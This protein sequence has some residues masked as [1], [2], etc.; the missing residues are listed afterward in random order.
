MTDFGLTFR[1]TAFQV[2][3]MVAIALFVFLARGPHDD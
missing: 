3:A 1:D 2:L